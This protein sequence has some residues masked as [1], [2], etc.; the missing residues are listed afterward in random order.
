MGHYDADCRITVKSRSA[1]QGNSDFINKFEAE[2][3]TVD[4]S[5]FST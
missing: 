3:L 2:D 5:L 1:I 4:M